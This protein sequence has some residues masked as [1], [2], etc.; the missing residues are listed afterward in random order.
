MAADERALRHHA[1]AFVEKGCLGDRQALLL[2][3]KA[4]DALDKTSVG[5]V[6]K[7]ALR[8]KHLS[9]GW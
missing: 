3:V 4:V 5:K 2:E 7:R 8:E 1:N 9:S 6:N